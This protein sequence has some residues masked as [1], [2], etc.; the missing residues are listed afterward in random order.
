MPERPA[1]LFVLSTND[2]Y[3]ACLSMLD[4]IAGMPSRGYRPL[5]ALK[6]PGDLGELLDRA[7]V[8][9]FPIQA[10]RWIGRRRSP[11]R[12]IRQRIEDLGTARSVA[13][14]AASHDVRLVHSNTLSSPVGAF[15]ASRVGVPHLW[16]MREAV[17]TEEGSTFVYGH[18]SSARLIG[19]ASRV[20]A[21]SQY[22]VEQTA[23]YADP[24]NLRLLYDGFLDAR[25]AHEPLP[26]RT[27]LSPDRTLRLLI[28]AKLN[29]RKGHR[30]VFGALAL[31]RRQGIDA[32]LTV[33]GDGKANFI[34]G[35]KN[36]AQSLGV[37]EA[38]DWVGYVDPAPYYASCDVSLMCGP[39]EPLAR[40]SVESQAAGVPSIAVRSGGLPE[41]VQDGVTG[42]LYR[43]GSSDD[44]ADRILAAV[45]TS[46]ATQREM[47][48]TGRRRVYTMFEAE[49]HRDE[50][51]GFYREMGVA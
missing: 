2:R 38:I 13:R 17:D 8:P 6:T 49:R 45:R 11:L 32:R 1:V 5:V 39:R 3:G 41:V 46:P 18:Q 36:L 37:S 43:E 48:E 33:L 19:K 47:R 23:R 40:V 34:H 20:V 14:L 42:W 31:L 21:C 28:V 51:V 22:L 44:L 4:L 29:V 9:W 7:G 12:R 10:K 26:E 15:V 25:K 24:Q 16:H 27:P 50:A 30:D 35:L